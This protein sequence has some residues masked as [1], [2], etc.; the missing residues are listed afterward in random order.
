MK[1]FLLL[2][3]TLLLLLP[4]LALAD[5]IDVT[6][7]AG[8]SKKVDSAILTDGSDDTVYKFAKA[9]TADLT[10]DLP[11]GASVRMA[12]VRVDSAPAK[13]ELQF[14]N[15]NKKWETAASME[16]P[17]PECVLTTVSKLTGRLRLLI[18]Y[19]ANSA[20]PLTELRIFSDI[21]LPEGLH[22]WKRAS[23]ADVLLTVDSIADVDAKELT[24]W[25][26]AG[27]SVAVASLSVPAS[28]LAATDALWDAGLRVT[29]VF[30]G[31]A[32]STKNAANTLKGWG[33][34][35]VVATV[36]SWLREMQP[37][38]LVDGGEVTAL[39]MTK[40]AASAIDPDYELED[41]ASGGLW[42]VPQ[43]MTLGKGD[44]AAA[45]EAMGQRDSSL[46]RQACL[47][48]FA[49]AAHS[50]AALIPYPDNRDEE[51]YLTEGEFLFEDAEKGLWAYLSTTVQVEIIQY[52]MVNPIQ[53]YFVADVKFKPESEMFKQHTWV[54]AEFVGQQI[55]PQTLAQSSRLVIAVNGDYYP[56][57]VDKGNTV[58][59]IMR[60]GRVL[61]DINKNKNPGFPNLDSL[62][63][64]DNG[65]LSVYGTKEITATELAAQGGIHD[66]LSFGPYM[67]RDGVLRVYSG[68]N[69]SLQEPR[70]AIGMVE[71]GHYVI[72]NCEGRVPKGPKGM[73]INQIGMLLYGHGCNESF[74]LDGG[75]TSVLIFMGEKLNRTGKDT[76]IG[77]PRN[78]HEL[79]GVGTSELVH[80]DWMNGKPKK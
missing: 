62:A 69:A 20:T 30:G 1:K 74:M 58:G 10:C 63:L 68:K 57:R 2:L 11:E 56:Y 18:T 71:A 35:K 26:A 3:L 22:E 6:W 25:L 77:S 61:Y 39:V 36:T 23:Q 34:K 41:A 33:E 24:N 29:P 50:D 52:D 19:A 31:Y 55:Y 47:V 17:G 67:A 53:R 66:V 8:G 43:T 27:R 12:Y 48:P 49:D 64:H 14:L 21:N 76:S 13:V 42:A 15:K 38:L 28:P 80:T 46:V 79:F 51:G 7:K 44:V 73:T 65:T 59:N 4:A 40:A 5:E 72:V 32:E 70:C 9:K 16:N 45:I 78:Q 37:M 75:S 60:S 54:D